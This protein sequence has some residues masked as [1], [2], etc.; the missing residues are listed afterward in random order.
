[1]LH[2]YYNDMILVFTSGADVNGQARRILDYDGATKFITVSVALNAEPTVGDDFQIV[3]QVVAAAAGGDATEA[4]QDIIDGIVDDI[5]ALLV[6][7]GVI[8]QL[9]DAIK[10]KTDTIVWGDITA[11]DTLIDGL[12]A[13]I[14]VFPTGSYA[15][16]AAYVEDIRAR[17]IVILA[18]TNEVQVSLADGGFTDL[19]IDSIIERTANLPDDPADASVIAAAHAL[20]ATVAKQDIIDGIVDDIKALLVDGGVIDQLIDDIKAKTD[21]LPVD[22]ADASDLATA[23]ALLATEAKQ[24]IIDTNV[25]TLL[26]R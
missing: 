14:G 5:K 8:D 2:D 25:D 24:D 23:H 11:L 20:L 16:L 10:A 15:T 6:D 18:D 1:M 17:L 4:K 22:P 13:D 21:N 19:L 7:G 3:P 26:T 9:I 12:V